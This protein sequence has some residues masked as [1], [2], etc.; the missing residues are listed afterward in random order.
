VFPN[1]A[2]QR[3]NKNITNEQATTAELLDGSSSKGSCNKKSS[4]LVLART[5]V[6]SEETVP[7]MFILLPQ[8][9][10]RLSTDKQH[11]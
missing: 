5:S 3:L 7:V 9:I 4:Q 2:R 1:V 8:K 6:C 11:Y 10:S